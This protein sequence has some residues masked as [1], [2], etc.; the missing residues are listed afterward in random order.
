MQGPVLPLRT[1]G[2]F[3]SSEMRCLMESLKP[4]FHAR[5][6]PYADSTILQSCMWLHSVTA[7]ASMPKA[8]G[9]NSHGRGRSPQ[10]TKASLPVNQHITM[11][12]MNDKATE[13]D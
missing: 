12:C 8:E 10:P 11:A 3:L 4:C 9:I 6:G 7:Q 1:A 13:I 5:C 2:A